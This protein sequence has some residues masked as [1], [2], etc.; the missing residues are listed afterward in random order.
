MPRASACVALGLLAVTADAVNLLRSS[1]ANVPTG[2][3]YE[4]EVTCFEDCLMK[5]DREIIKVD[6]ES[7]T[8]YQREK[9]RRAAAKKVV[10][11]KV[12]QETVHDILKG[13]FTKISMKPSSLAQTGN[14]SALVNSTTGNSS[15]LGASASGNATASAESLRKSTA[16]HSVFNWRRDGPTESDEVS[17]VVAR[18]AQCLEA[19]K[20]RGHRATLRKFSSPWAARVLKNPACQK[21]KPSQINLLDSR[22]AQC[23]RPREHLNCSVGICGARAL[24]PASALV[25][26]QKHVPLHP[27]V[28]GSFAKGVQ[29]LNMCMGSCLAATCGCVSGSDRLGGFEKIDSLAKQIKAN[30][31]AGDPVLD[32]P[33]E[34]TYR[35]AFKEECGNGAAGIKI[36]SGLYSVFSK[37]WFEVCSEDY[38]KSMMIK[39]VKGATDHCRDS[40]EN[41]VD[42]GCLWS[43]HK[44]ACVWGLKPAV[45]CSVRELKDSKL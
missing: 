7:A 31:A 30:D 8:K 21:P 18:Y 42:Y 3:C 25:Q 4:C 40:S 24:Q 9:K 16:G 14:S 38:I 33:P 22:G 11:T 17:A 43:P 44:N 34:Y 19:E 6:A 41:S 39:D 13:V 27:V 5:Y 15:A 37:G 20:C 23:S 35:P 12:E 26:E 1:V 36:T 2:E 10:N 45:R 28:V 29:T 32:T